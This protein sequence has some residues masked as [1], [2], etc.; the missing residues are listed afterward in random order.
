V[1]DAGPFGRDDGSLRTPPE[2]DDHGGVAVADVELDQ[3]LTSRGWVEIDRA[4]GLTMYDWLP[5]APDH[6]HEITYLIVDLRGVAGVG[7]PYRVSDV[8]GDRLTYEVRSAL[9]E[10]LDTIEAIRCAGC[11]TRMKQRGSGPIGGVL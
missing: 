8:N 7:P 11:V 4:D 2:S 1:L 5:S 10:D 3:L 9:I 6:D